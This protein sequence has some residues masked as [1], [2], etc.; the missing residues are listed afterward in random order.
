MPRMP[1]DVVISISTSSR[2]LSKN[3]LTMWSRPGILAGLFFG[4]LAVVNAGNA[5]QKPQDKEPEADLEEFGKLVDQVDPRSLHAALHDYSP[6]KFKHGM[7]KEDRTA[8]EAIHKEQPS[9][10]STIVAIAKRQN[11][12]TAPA[13]S[14]PAEG[15]PTTTPEVESPTDAGNS[16]TTPAVATPTPIGPVQGSVIETPGNP[17]TPTTTVGGSPD[18]PPETITSTST[19]ANG[20]VGGGST[21]TPSAEGDVTGIDE[22]SAATTT[23]APGAISSFTAGEVI[24]TTNAEGVTIVSTI[25]GGYV[26]LSSSTRG[27]SPTTTTPATRNTRRTSSTSVVL[28]TTTL[29]DGSQSTVTAVT[30]VPGSDEAAATPSG[31]AGAGEGSTTQGGNPALQTGVAGKTGSQG[32]ELVCLL[33]AAVGWAMMM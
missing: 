8:V 7:F 21:P 14:P 2:S 16:P 20:V 3:Q 13:S 6:K 15:S 17:G 25:G 10:A 27:R 31:E 32:W 11:N 30:V 23:S 24:T 19:S 1:L 4:L 9:L 5:Q 33:G 22:P 18:Q 12:G 29:P 26:T 28:Q